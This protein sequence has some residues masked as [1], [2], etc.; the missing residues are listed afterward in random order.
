MFDVIFSFNLTIH[1]IF[2]RKKMEPLENPPENVI[3][4]G[5]FIDVPCL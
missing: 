5:L 3:E 1:D 4:S 2:P